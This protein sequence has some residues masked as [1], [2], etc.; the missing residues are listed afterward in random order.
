MS[1]KLIQTATFLIRSPHKNVYFPEIL[2]DNKIIVKTF[3]LPQGM[4]SKFQ[5]VNIQSN[6]E[7]EPIVYRFTF[8]IVITW[9]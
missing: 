7:E 9:H 2:V 6:T 1:S 5:I 8:S 3:V 4:K